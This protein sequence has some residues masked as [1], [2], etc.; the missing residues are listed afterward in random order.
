MVLLLRNDRGDCRLVI[1]RGVG[2][3]VGSGSGRCCRV[4]SRRR[5]CIGQVLLRLMVCTQHAQL[6]KC[7]PHHG[8]ELQSRGVVR[9]GHAVAVGQL[10]DAPKQTETSSSIGHLKCRF[11]AGLSYRGALA[12][13]QTCQVR[14]QYTICPPFKTARHSS[15]T[16]THASSMLTLQGSLSGSSAVSAS[17]SFPSCMQ[18]SPKR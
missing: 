17:C 9:Y 14:K 12:G 8:I 6:L 10:V 7:C 2:S 18:H 3:N 4:R 11:V 5:R 15:L 13:L 16:A 1:L